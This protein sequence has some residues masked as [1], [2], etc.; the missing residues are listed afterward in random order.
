MSEVKLNEPECIAELRRKD[1]IARNTLLLYFVA[2]LTVA[3][4]TP[5]NILEYPW[6]RWFVNFMSFIPYVEKAGQASPIPQIAQFF[7][8]VMCILSWVIILP[9]WRSAYSL[10]QEIANSR[11]RVRQIFKWLGAVILFIVPVVWVI[12]YPNFD[13]RLGQIQ[14]SSRIGMGAY[15]TFVL[16]AVPFF[17]MVVVM[18]IKNWR[19]IVYGDME[20]LIKRNSKFH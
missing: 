18:L 5:E 15:G 13:S 6:A 16:G 12:F 11:I 20:E 4:V 10:P 17:L 19:H 2:G 8:A 3:F 7:A 1:H 9:M 14:I